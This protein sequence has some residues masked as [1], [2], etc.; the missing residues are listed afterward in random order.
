[1]AF[2]K[3]SSVKITSTITN[4]SCGLDALG[5]RLG[6]RWDAPSR[7][8]AR[9]LLRSSLAN[10]ASLPPV[11]DFWH[12]AGAAQAFELGH[13]AFGSTPPQLASSAL[14]RDWM[15]L[16]STYITDNELGVL[17][18]LLEAVILVWQP[19]RGGYVC[20]AQIVPTTA[21]YI[22]SVAYQ[23]GSSFTNNGHYE[24]ISMVDGSSLEALTGMHCSIPAEVEPWCLANQDVVQSVAAIRASITGM[25]VKTPNYIE[26]LANK[27]NSAACSLAT[28]CGCVQGYSPVAANAQQYLARQPA[29][30]GCACLQSNTHT[31]GTSACGRFRRWRWRS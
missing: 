20:I 10:A 24:G 28:R 8:S 4:G 17:A 19:A 27:I 15:A 31:S 29:S 22:T 2:I 5:F 16:D 14:Y 30:V 25:V 21:R 23:R 18:E 12:R 26:Y 1:M 7:I 6:K 3:A 9:H 11:W 13:K